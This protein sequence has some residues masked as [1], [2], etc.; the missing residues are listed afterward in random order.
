MGG[1]AGKDVVC[2]P[3]SKDCSVIFL[4][5]QGTMSDDNVL[6]ESGMRSFLLRVH[7][8]QV[9]VPSPRPHTQRTRL[10]MST[11]YLKLVSHKSEAGRHLSFEKAKN[12]AT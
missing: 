11:I 4:T 5:K 3:P 10:V 7:L 1:E 6:R 12:S 8:I 2:L 9:I